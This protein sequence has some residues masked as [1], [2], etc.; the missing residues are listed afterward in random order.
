V[1]PFHLPISRLRIH[2]RRRLVGGGHRPALVCGRAER[3]EV[4]AERVGGQGHGGEDQDENHQEAGQISRKQDERAGEGQGAD[5]GAQDPREAPAHQGR[6]GAGGRQQDEEECPDQLPGAGDQY[7]QNRDERAGE[8]HQ[9]EDRGG[10]GGRG[11][12]EGS[13][14]R[15]PRVR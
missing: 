14:S 5:H 15:R 1:E 9:C 8:H 13:S 12:A 4:S 3:R 7:D 10:G 6:P 11:A 2:D